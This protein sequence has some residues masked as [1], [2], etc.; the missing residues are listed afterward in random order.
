MKKQLFQFNRRFSR[1]KRRDP[2]GGWVAEPLDV[3]VL[4]GTLIL[5]FWLQLL[6]L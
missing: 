6:P 5:V 1:C 3:A 4:T 2:G